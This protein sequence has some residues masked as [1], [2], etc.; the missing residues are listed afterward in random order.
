MSDLKRVAI[1]MGIYGGG[2][3]LLGFL[4]GNINGFINHDWLD[5][6]SKGYSKAS[7]DESKKKEDK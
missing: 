2:M 7:E 4:T 1:A 3:W 5:G 6:Y